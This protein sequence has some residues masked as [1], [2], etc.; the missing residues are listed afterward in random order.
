M[1]IVAFSALAM[2]EEP[3][4]APATTGDAAKTAP[5]TD[6]ATADKAEKTTETTKKT[7]KTAS[8]AKHHGKKKAADSTTPAN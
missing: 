7:T 6:A 5:T 2:A 4:T 1:A 8:K 3:A